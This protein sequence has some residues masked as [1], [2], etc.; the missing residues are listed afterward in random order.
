[1]VLS[2]AFI[3]AFLLLLLSRHDFVVAESESEGRGQT[4]WKNASRS[5][6]K[7]NILLILADD[8]G[9]GDIPYYWKENSLVNT[10]NIDKLSEMGVTFMDAHSTPLCAPSRY[11]LLS[12]NYAHRGYVPKGTWSWNDR[13]SNQF[14]SGQKSIAEILRDQA[15]YSTAMFGKW[16]MG[17]GVPRNEGVDFNKT[18]ILTD[19]RHDWSQKIIDGPSDVGFETSLITTA[20]I[21]APPY[22]FF[23]DGFLTIDQSDAVFWKGGSYQMPHG[24][25]KIAGGRKFEGEGAEDWDSSAYNM[26]LVNETKKFVENHLEN[27]GENP[28]FAY[29]ALGAVHSPHSPPDSY[30]DGDPIAGQYETNHLDMLLEMDKVVGSLVSIIEDKNLAEDTIIIFTSDNGGLSPGEGTDY[31]LGHRSSGPLRGHKALVSFVFLIVGNL[32]SFLVKNGWKINFKITPYMNRC[33][34]EDIGFL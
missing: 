25:S 5:S 2:N 16:H 19:D 6:R 27:E 32:D 34:R 24:T 15:D 18:H 30:I 10:P 3:L 17:A 4:S 22:V 29:V 8:V 33:T 7:P 20:G 13:N 9:T 26:I 12:G 14:L 21:Q 28:F 23:K 31:S 11:M 1:M